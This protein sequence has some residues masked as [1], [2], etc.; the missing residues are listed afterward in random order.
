MVL[1]PK[2]EAIGV[3]QILQY[4][5]QSNAQSEYDQVVITDC[6]IP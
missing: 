3:R 5:Q 2:V 4:T 1:S 6:G